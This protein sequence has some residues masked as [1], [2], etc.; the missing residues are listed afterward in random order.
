MK[1]SIPVYYAVPMKQFD[2]QA[3]DCEETSSVFCEIYTGCGK[4]T[5]F[6]FVYTHIKKEVSLPHPVLSQ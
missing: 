1:Y 4:L 3:R 6:L 5:Y 2:N